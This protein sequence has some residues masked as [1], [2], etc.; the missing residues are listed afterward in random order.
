MWLSYA[1]TTVRC[2]YSSLVSVIKSNLWKLVKRRNARWIVLR[3]NVLR[4]IVNKPCRAYRQRPAGFPHAARG[5]KY[6]SNLLWPF[7][8]VKP[9]SLPKRGRRQPAACRHARIL[10]DRAS[11][12]RRRG[13]TTRKIRLTGSKGSR[14]AKTVKLRYKSAA[15]DRRETRCASNMAAGCR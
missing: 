12:R 7:V 4:W 11:L 3:W 10:T 1:S 5:N 6:L 9:S 13:T 2:R 15:T 14:R 8:F